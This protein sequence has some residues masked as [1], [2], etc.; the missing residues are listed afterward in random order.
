MPTSAIGK[1]FAYTLKRWDKLTKYV[2]LGQ[3][4]IDNNLV[5]NVIRPI[6][7]GRKNYLFAGSHEG[8]Q[9]RNDIFTIRTCKINNLNPM[10]WLQDIFLRI[11]DHPINQI[12][13]LLPH[14]WIKTRSEI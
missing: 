2:E 12:E 6:A 8:A 13:D 1:A 4:E 9:R 11:N 3:V 10:E 14:N 7:L 5:E